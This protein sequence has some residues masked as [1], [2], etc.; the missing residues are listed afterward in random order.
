MANFANLDVTKLLLGTRFFYTKDALT[1]NF[2]KVLL[3]TVV[4]TL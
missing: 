2:Y 1:V 4:D 3:P